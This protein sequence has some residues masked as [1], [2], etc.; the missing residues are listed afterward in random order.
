ME[1]VYQQA[2]HT[3]LSSP[4]MYVE[5]FRKGVEALSFLGLKPFKKLLLLGVGGSG[6]VG[7]IVAALK[8][9]SSE[10]FVHTLKDFRT[11]QWVGSD[12]L[13]VAVSYSGNTA[14]TVLASLDAL[15]KGAQVVGV[16]SGGRLTEIFTSKGVSVVEVSQGLQPR[17]AVPEMVGAV[18]G[19]LSC[20]EGFPASSFKKAARELSDYLKGFSGWEDGGILSTAESFLG[21]VV[22]CISHSHLA[23]AASRLKAQL[24]ENAKHQAYTV[25]LPEACHNEVEGWPE[26]GNFNFVLQ[27]SVFEHPIYSD[28][29][30]WMKDFIICR[31]GVCREVV[32]QSTEFRDELLKHIS[33]ADLVSIALAKLKQVNPFE[34]HTIPLLRPKLRRHLP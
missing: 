27:R 20:A 10:L 32:I 4:K 9:P 31:G 1:D 2:W 8:E 30:E 15:S 14:E 22:V 18:Y 17:Y 34:L 33:Y 3:V 23:A 13:A 16:S 19:I 24:N 7:D 21:R 12:T 5:G 28:V 25:L 6:I 26:A 11:P 29:F